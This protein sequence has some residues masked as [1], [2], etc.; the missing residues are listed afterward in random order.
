MYIV[1][2]GGGKV[3]LALANTLIDKKHTVAIVEKRPEVGERLASELCDKGCI[4]ILG[5]GCDARVLDEAG[6]ARADIFVAVTGEDD[7]NLVSCQ[8]A[9]LSFDVPRAISR[10][11]S[12]KNQQ[13]F[14]K[15]GIEAISSTM[16][17]S[18]LIEEEATIGDLHTLRT[19]RQGNLALVEIELSSDEG[20][21]RVSNKR[22]GQIKL[23]ANVKLVAVVHSESDDVDIVTPETVLSCGD[24][25][26]AIA[27][28]KQEIALARVLRGA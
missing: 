28:P 3:A 12:P 18:N 23:P 16:V 22:V 10:V 2:N 20:I 1:L 21:C 13:I 14:A 5:D 24:I 7:D 27:D 17:I 11:N 19:L 6:V 9:R 26:I 25:V 8:L 15:L 4:V